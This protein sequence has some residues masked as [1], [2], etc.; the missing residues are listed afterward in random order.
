MKKYLTM[1]DVLNITG[2]SRATLYRH[3]NVIGDFPKPA[4]KV[5]DRLNRWS[6]EQ[7]DQWLEQQRIELNG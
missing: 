5:F 2:I 1:K 4:F 3:M 7:I 6:N